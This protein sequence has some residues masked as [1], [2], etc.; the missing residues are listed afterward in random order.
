MGHEHLHLMMRNLHAA[1][2]EFMQWYRALRQYFLEYHHQ[3]APD[4]WEPLPPSAGVRPNNDR[5]MQLTSLRPGN[6]TS[7]AIGKNSNPDPYVFFIIF[8]YFIKVSTVKYLKFNKLIYTLR[9]D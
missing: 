1:N 3:K 6:A 2:E 9:S 5:P 4:H 8:S 7:W